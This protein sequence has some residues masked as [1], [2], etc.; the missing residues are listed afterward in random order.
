MIFT[1]NKGEMIDEAKEKKCLSEKER[2]L[3][4]LKEELQRFMME[5]TT[6]TRIVSNLIENSHYFFPYLLSSPKK[7]L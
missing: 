1:Q 4:D 7:K 3:T 6:A 2:R 5:D